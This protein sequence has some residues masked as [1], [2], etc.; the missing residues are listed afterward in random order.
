MDDAQEFLSFFMLFSVIFTME[1][2]R[3]CKNKD[4]TYT[5]AVT[6]GNSLNPRPGGLGFKQFP[7]AT[8]NVNA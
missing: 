8:A 1:S 4:H 2:L 6:L 5:L 3:K 7:C